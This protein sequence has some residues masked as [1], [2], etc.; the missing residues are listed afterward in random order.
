MAVGTYSAGSLTETWNGSSWSVVSSQNPG[1]TDNLES[2]SCASSTSCEAVGFDSSGHGF[3]TLIESWNGTGWTTVS[4]PNQGTGNNYLY[5][6]SCVGTSYCAAV[7]AF[8]SPAQPLVEAWNGTS[9]SIV[10]SPTASSSQLQAVSCSTATA[11]VATGY[12]GTTYGALA[13]TWNGTSWSTTSTGFGTG[14]MWHGVSCTSSTNCLAVGEGSSATLIWNWNGT[15]W[16]SASNPE[17]GTAP[18]LYGVACTTANSCVAVGDYTT[19]SDNALVETGLTPGPPASIVASSGT[20][21]AALINTAFR[22]PLRAKVTDAS[23][24]PIPGQTVTFAAPTTGASGSFAG[25]VTTAVTDGSGIATSPKFTA[26]GVAGFYTVTASLNGVST[27][28]SF[29]L[30]NRVP[31][32]ISSFSPLSGAVGT[33]VAIVGQNLGQAKKVTFGGTAAVITRDSPTKI[34]AA[35]PSGA[36][37]GPITVTT[38]GGTAT[39]SNRF[40]VT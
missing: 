34:V 6:L 4:S 13:E 24:V 9:W 22:L 3:R 17:P 32:V 36:V 27:H 33:Q 5:G 37:T 7:G 38:L 40:T 35:V 20:P 28:A 14:I 1:T 16:S 23:G 26:N 8:G 31:P 18:K 2:V 21:Q 15:T 12:T 10:T 30:T 25:N 11:C 29:L 19:S 39:S